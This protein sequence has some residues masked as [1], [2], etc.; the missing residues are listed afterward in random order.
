MSL[1]WISRLKEREWMAALNPVTKKISKDSISGF[2]KKMDFQA[3]WKP[4]EMKKKKLIQSI[5]FYKP[6][7][8]IRDINAAK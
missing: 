4:H 5:T 6:S 1:S 3:F 7:Y 2:D 8:V